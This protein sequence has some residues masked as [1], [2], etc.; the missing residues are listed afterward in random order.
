MITKK[1]AKNC[2]DCLDTFTLLNA[3]HTRANAK[4][5]ITCTTEEQV[6]WCNE[7][8]DKPLTE[9]GKELLTTLWQKQELP[10]LALSELLG[11]DNVHGARVTLR[12]M[13]MF[14]VTFTLPPKEKKKI[15]EDSKVWLTEHPE[16]FAT[17]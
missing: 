8:S 16:L 14:F 1:F 5:K 12:A 9:F 10:P 7:D 4:G 2:I 17:A 13:K 15:M 6:Q 11:E 3:L